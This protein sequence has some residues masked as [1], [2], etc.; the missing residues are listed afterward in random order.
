MIAV[1]T[2]FFIVFLRAKFTY[3]IAKPYRSIKF[4]L[5]NNVILYVNNIQYYINLTR[6]R[7][8]FSGFAIKRR[9]RKN[10]AKL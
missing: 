4:I 7:H 3:I 8:E 9:S 1:K 6:Y 5:N 10:A 2:I